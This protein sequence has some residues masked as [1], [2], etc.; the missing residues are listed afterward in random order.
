VAVAAVEQ[1]CSANF[2]SWSIAMI[3][4]IFYTIS[5][6]SL[7]CHAHAADPDP[8]E[9]PETALKDM[10][11]LMEKKDF[12]TFYT[13]YM[14]PDRLKGKTEKQ[15]KDE[16]AKF[17]SGAEAKEIFESMKVHQAVKPEIMKDDA[18][19]VE[20]ARFKDPNKPALEGRTLIKIGK[21]WYLY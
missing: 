20:L 18:R 11:A 6:A 19:G 5:F 8:R 7:V 2:F 14:E 3:R 13:R 16:A 17:G 15:I 10:I 21:Y 9:K 12:F 1:F 4:A